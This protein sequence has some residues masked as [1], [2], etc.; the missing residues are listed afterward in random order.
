MFA[1]TRRL[2]TLFE[3]LVVGPP[4]ARNLYADEKAS[5]PS[6]FRFIVALSNPQNS[7]TGISQPRSRGGSENA[8]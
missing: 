6:S 3:D 5:V 7:A 1:G 2:C 4:I 8:P